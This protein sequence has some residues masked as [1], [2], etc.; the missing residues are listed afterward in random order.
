MEVASAAAGG[1]ATRPPSPGA[2]SPRAPLR[3]ASRRPPPPLFP[4]P[5]LRPRSSLRPSHGPWGSRA[6]R[7]GVRGPAWRGR[8]TET[9]GIPS[10][11]RTC[12]VAPGE[13]LWSLSLGF[14][15]RG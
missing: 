15:V 8:P 6:P 12:S 4:S 9:S 14:L 3:V 1:A 5:H 13:A 7:G 2:P 10:S 11:A